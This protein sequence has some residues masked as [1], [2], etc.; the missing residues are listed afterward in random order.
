MIIF[1]YGDDLFRSGQKLL[2][3][4]EKFLLTNL[5][6]AGL[7]VFD[8]GSVNNAAHS[9]GGGR[10]TNL[11]DV[12]AMPNLLNPKRLAIVKNLIS[13]A[14]EE[15]REIIL[16]YLKENTAI[17]KDD[18]LVVVFFE[19]NLPKKNSALFK[20][21]SKEAK[22]QNFEKLS[23]IKIDQWV[24]KRIKEIDPQTDIEASA[25]EKLVAFS[26]GD[27][28]VFNSE[29]QKLVSFT[30]GKI[31]KDDD[32]E[33]LVNENISIKIFDT[34]DALGSNNKKRA[35]GLLH[36]HLKRGEDPFYIFSMF[37]YQFRNLL[38]VADLKENTRGGEYEI[39]RMSGLHPFVVKKSL[40][41]IRNFSF[42]RLKKIYQELSE[43]DTKIKTGKIDIRLALDKFI[44]EL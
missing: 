27:T 32:V 4:K 18:D 28:H 30:D 39:S 10:E 26:G 1:L 24:I 25:L 23:G 22:S 5:A 41:Q 8:Y 11:L 43:V 44:V 16:K 40:A 13:E 42:D 37:V 17:A 33:K 21:L 6:G 36:E 34:I 19:N 38:K 12:L 14:T 7:S 3:I 35:V 15:E 20:F 9:A 31:I 2:Q 29:I